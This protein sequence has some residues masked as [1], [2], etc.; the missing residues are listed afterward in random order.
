[1][2]KPS[3]CVIT[4][5]IGR[6]TLKRTLESAVLSKDDIWY[7]IQDKK[8]S[9]H[10]INGPIFPLWRDLVDARPWLFFLSPNLSSDYGNQLRD[11]AMKMYPSRDYY[12]VFLDDDDIF[13]PNAIEI[14]KGEIAKHKPRPII[15]KMIN[16]NGEILWRNREVTPGN[17]GGSMFVCP[18]DPEKLG[19]WDNRQGHRS[20]YEFI[21]QT[22]ENY[23]PGWRQEIV[24]SDKIIIRCRPER[25]ENE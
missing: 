9:N 5:T 19:K 21:R 17:V 13:M 22:L 20:D 16:G 6:P 2:S 4:P 12:F 15:F 24:W 8:V 11:R 25:G 3:I 7:I 10:N 1:M 18:N 23:G 14:I